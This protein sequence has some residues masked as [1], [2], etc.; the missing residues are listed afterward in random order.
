MILSHYFIKNLRRKACTNHTI[1][2]DKMGLDV[3]PRGQH[4]E[5]RVT[6]FLP[7]WRSNSRLFL[8]LQTCRMS[9]GIHRDKD[10]NVHLY[11]C[12][13]V[14]FQAQ[15]FQTDTM[16]NSKFAHFGNS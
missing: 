16:Q 11:C 10:P 7:G 15:A 1:A 4:L 14:R 8:Q 9:P 3:Q 12:K 13:N 5:L 6:L 2:R